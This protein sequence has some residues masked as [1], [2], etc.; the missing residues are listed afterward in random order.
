MTRSSL[1]TIL[2]YN[3]SGKHGMYKTYQ[4]PFW[5]GL[6][7]LSM[8]YSSMENLA[9]I[10]EPQVQSNEQKIHKLMEN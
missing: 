8:N 2:S 6:S 1:V 10:S 3:L 9:D 4:E 7:L 5:E